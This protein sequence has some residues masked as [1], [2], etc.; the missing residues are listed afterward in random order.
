MN[1][2]IIN[3]TPCK[4]AGIT[5]KSKL[6]ERIYKALKS[7]GIDAKYEEKTFVLSPKIKAT[8]PAYYRTKQK[9]FHKMSDTVLAVTYTPD[10]TFVLNHIYVIMEA[11][12]K[13]NDVY[14]L[15][16]NLFRKLLES[17]QIPVM[18]F[19][20]HSKKEALE[21]IKIVKQTDVSKLI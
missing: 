9:G 6:E 5:F 7:L 15:K 14:P 18:F 1:K 2:K 12:G 17:V 11:K 16:R 21:A 8:V 19:E 20:V 13:E 4:F 3:A 10:F